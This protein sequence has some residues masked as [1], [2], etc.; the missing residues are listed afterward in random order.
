MNE[1][2]GTLEAGE[3]T[4]VLEVLEYRGGFFW[5]DLTDAGDFRALRLMFRNN[6][7]ADIWDVFGLCEKNGM[8]YGT[9]RGFTTVIGG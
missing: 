2:V 6:P 4:L 7:D 1:F 5:I 3:Q 9:I 8:R